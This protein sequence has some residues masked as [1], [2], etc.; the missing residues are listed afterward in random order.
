MIQLNFN[1]SG[2]PTEPP[3]IVLE[4][5]PRVYVASLEEPGRAIFR[6]DP[7][8][9]PHGF[10]VFWGNKIA[11]SVMP[12]TS[13]SY[14]VSVHLSPPLPILDYAP[15]V[16][17]VQRLSTLG[18]A[19]LR[20]DGSRWY[21]K[22]ATDFRL[23]Q[24]FLAREDIIPLLLQRKAAG[25]NLVRV[26]A[27]KANN[28]GWELNPHSVENYWQRLHDFWTLIENE[29]LYVEHTVFCDTRALMPDQTP[30]QVF[31]QSTVE[32]AAE[33]PNVLLELINEAGHSTQSCN[34]AAFFRPAT[35]TPASHGSGGTDESPV[36]PLW[37]FATY[38]ARR[39]SPPDARGFTNYNVY[40]FESSVDGGI[41]G[42]P[43]PCPFIPDEGMKPQNYEY[44]P[45]AAAMMGKHC[46]LHAGG[47]F[48]TDINSDY[49][50]ERVEACARAFYAEI[51]DGI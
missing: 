34:P 45:A 3:T 27:M 43:K 5:S 42:W 21:W 37:D 31:W 7:N 30:Q 46:A 26:V 35:G 16:P 49:W 9:A 48:H 36:K 18:E 44:D 22:G 33:H 32:R 8:P 28:T 20:Q 14:E 13:G 40:G 6:M 51:P 24:R 39:E 11:R 25:A 12:A 1:T 2:V 50:D 23:L 47:T 29:G 15:E 4:T 41:A 10:H 17:G 38:H 19:F